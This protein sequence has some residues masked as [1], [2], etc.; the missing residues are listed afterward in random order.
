M[1][2][3]IPCLVIIMLALCPSL[4]DIKNKVLYS[5]KRE[6]QMPLDQQSRLKTNF[7]PESLKKTADARDALTPAALGADMQTDSLGFSFRLLDQKDQK[8]NQGMTQKQRGLRLGVRVFSKLFPFSFPSC[9]LKK[10]APRKNA[11]RAIPRLAQSDAQV[12]ISQPLEVFVQQKILAQIPMDEKSKPYAEKKEIRLQSFSDDL[13]HHGSTEIRTEQGCFHDVSAKVTREKTHGAKKICFENICFENDLDGKNDSTRVS[14]DAAPVDAKAVDFKCSFTTHQVFENAPVFYSQACQKYPHQAGNHNEDAVTSL[15]QTEQSCPIQALTPETKK[16]PVNTLHPVDECIDPELAWAADYNPRDDIRMLPRMEPFFE[17]CVMEPRDNSEIFLPKT[18]ALFVNEDYTYTNEMNIELLPETPLLLGPNEE[19]LRAQAEAAEALRLADEAEKSRLAAQQEAERVQ[20]AEAAEALRLA[21]EEAA[22]AQRLADEAEKSR[23][24]AEALRLA[25]EEKSRLAAQKEA[26][27]L[28]AQQ[29]V[30]QA[31]EAA[32]AKRL[33][34]EK[35]RLLEEEKSRLAAQKEA[36]ELRAQ[37]AEAEAQR[38]EQ[39]TNL[40]STNINSD[41]TKFN[42]NFS[43]DLLIEPESLLINTKS[44]LRKPEHIEKVALGECYRII[45]GSL[46]NQIVRFIV[47]EKCRAEY[48]IFKT[49]ERGNNWGKIKGWFGIPKER[50]L[51][52]LLEWGSLYDINGLPIHLMEEK[53]EEKLNI[54]YLEKCPMSDF[55]NKNPVIQQDVTFAKIDYQN[56]VTNCCM[57]KG[58]CFET[59]SE[60][61]KATRVDKKPLYKTD[62]CYDSQNLVKYLEFI[63]INGRGETAGQKSKPSGLLKIL[64]NDQMTLDRKMLPDG[65]MED[66]LLLDGGKGQ[67]SILKEDSIVIINDIIQEKDVKNSG[68]TEIRPIGGDALKII[69]QTNPQ[70]SQL[71]PKKITGQRGA[72]NNLTIDV[73]SSVL[74]ERDPNTPHPNTPQN[75]QDIKSAYETNTPVNKNK[76]R[77]TSKTSKKINEKNENTPLFKKRKISSQSENRLLE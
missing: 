15:V 67:I 63:K 33:A 51:R 52:R 10:K 17:N 47:S 50:T 18:D 66:I 8:T 46:K 32:E 45:N 22:E 11:P 9:F 26:D 35:K 16:T 69:T 40:I 7:F 31:A 56:D 77:R 2:K 70:P 65:G 68:D 61:Y 21:E 6:Y 55:L 13:G 60:K 12:Q 3:V 29:A 14:I 20:Q 44:L 27:E 38:L 57:A 73:K 76:A 48:Q 71:K 39:K 41:S 28:R 1:K 34:E 36:D 23:L 58:G 53:G 5:S 74:G 24:A 30:E 19:L 72:S 62:F 59:T 4:I 75:Q 25:E 54:M 37:Q 42:S 43:F 64:Q 49:E